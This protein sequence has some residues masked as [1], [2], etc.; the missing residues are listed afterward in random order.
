MVAKC[1]NMPLQF[2]EGAFDPKPVT[3][4]TDNRQWIK[5]KAGARQYALNP[6]HFH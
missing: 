6:L 1:A 2:S 5:R 4:K 3:V